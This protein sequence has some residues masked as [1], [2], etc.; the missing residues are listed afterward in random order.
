MTKETTA[1]QR[2]L[3]YASQLAGL[4]D[5]ASISGIPSQTTAQ[6]IQHHAHTL[7]QLWER[8]PDLA[9]KTKGERFAD[10][11]MRRWR[12][13]LDVMDVAAQMIDENWE[14]PK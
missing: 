10:E 6:S 2:A 14:P 13:N 1:S 4:R 9:P 7:D 12:G 11:M 8:C 5:W 3:D